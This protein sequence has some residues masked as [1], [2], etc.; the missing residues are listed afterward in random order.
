MLVNAFVFVSAWALAGIAFGLIA[1]STILLLAVVWDPGMPS[2]PAL[3]L[4][5]WFGFPNAIA[6]L[7]VAGAS[8]AGFVAFVLWREILQQDLETAESRL[9]RKMLQKQREGAFT[10]S[11]MVLAIMLVI[12]YYFPRWLGVFLSIVEAS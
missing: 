3:F 5:Y 6:L 12:F 10:F 11:R 4:P 1:G 2:A 8:G 7:S 9:E